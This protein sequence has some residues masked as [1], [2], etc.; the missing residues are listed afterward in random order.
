MVRII[1]LPES[2]YDSFVKFD[3]EKQYTKQVVDDPWSNKKHL[4]YRIYFYN[5]SLPYSTI[6]A[7]I[8]DFMRQF[9]TWIPELVFV[10][11]KTLDLQY[12]V[13][14]C[15]NKNTYFKCSAINELDQFYCDVLKT[16]LGVSGRGVVT[17]HKEMNTDFE[18]LFTMKVEPVH[19]IDRIDDSSIS[20]MLMDVT[21][22]FS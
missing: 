20:E 5:S 17:V 4:K 13:I 15:G 22:V 7:E 18:Q 9:E 6:K 8:R 11:R 2:E 14:Y 10:T 21:C 16:I 19:R 1:W 12:D 3:K